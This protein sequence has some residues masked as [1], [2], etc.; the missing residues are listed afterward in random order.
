MKTILAAMLILALGAPAGAADLGNHS[1]IVKNDSHVLQNPASDREGGETI[2]DAVPIL[3]IPFADTGAT[4]DNIDDYDSPCPYYGS[5]S[6]DV[7]YS[8]TPAYDLAIN[9]DLCYS[10]Y[11]TKVYVFN[12]AE[13]LV[14]CNDDYYTGP[15]CGSYVSF[16]PDVILIGGETYYI[17]IDGY[18]GDCGEYELHIFESLPCCVECPADGVHED[19]PTLRGWLRGQLQWR[20]QQRACGF[21]TAGGQARWLCGSCA[22]SAAGTR[23]EVQT[24]GIP[25]GSRPWGQ[26]KK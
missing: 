26:V 16:I 2:A 3:N 11:D 5:T 22:E 14:A 9:I 23:L 18:G 8:L 24:T 21:S 1:D 6:P 12:Q 25:T 19:E 10:Q 20:L 17:I 13:E 4:C 7:V 15:P